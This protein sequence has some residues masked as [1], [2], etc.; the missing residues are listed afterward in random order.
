MYTV[1]ICRVSSKIKAIP[2]K[3]TGKHKYSFQRIEVPPLPV[4]FCDCEDHSVPLEPAKRNHSGLL[5][6]S[7]RN[8]TND[9]HEVDNYGVNEEELNMM[10]S[11]LDKLLDKEIHS[12]IVPSKAE[13]TEEVQHDTSL[14]DKWQ[15][16]DNEEDQVSEEDNLV[17]NIVRKSSKKDTSFE[18]WGLKSSSANQVKH[19]E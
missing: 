1:T 2:L 16:D 5:A 12:E 3:G 11:I 14:V 13:P 19:S 8:N 4:H 15:V 7:Q 10:K 17:I 6:P 9:D 18:D